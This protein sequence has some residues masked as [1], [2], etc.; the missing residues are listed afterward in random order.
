[1]SLISALD[2]KKRDLVVLVGGGGKTTIMS[3]LAGE[4]LTKGNKV[5]VTTTTKIYPPVGSI[6]A[7]VVLGDGDLRAQIADKLRLHNYIV[8]GKELNFENKITGLSGDE[9]DKVYEIKELDFLLVEGDGA[10]G[11]AFKAPRAYEPVIPDRATVVVPVV[12]ADC[13]GKPLT[14]KHFHAVEQIIGLTGL[15]YGEKVSERAV[16][17][18]L[19]HEKGYRKQVPG[20]AR[21]IPFINKVDFVE[22]E[23]IIAELARILKDAGAERVIAGSAKFDNAVKEIY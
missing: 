18:I 7:A 3:R 12:G 17:R 13:L 16:A 8:A 23:R 4:A 21:W 6:R 20:H 10:K 9:V 2:L 11:K 5:L 22:D 14:E 19:L 1:M 15:S